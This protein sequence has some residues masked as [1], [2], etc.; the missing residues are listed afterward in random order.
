MEGKDGEGTMNREDLE[1]ENRGKG[2]R[3][4]NS[5]KVGEGG[6]LGGC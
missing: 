1:R 6:K 3:G 5:M 2:G 4:E